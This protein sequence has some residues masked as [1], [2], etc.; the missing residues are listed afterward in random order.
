MKKFELLLLKQK[1]NQKQKTKIIF[2][3]FN[4]VT[5]K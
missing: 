4:F 3:K 5:N 2:I 1:K